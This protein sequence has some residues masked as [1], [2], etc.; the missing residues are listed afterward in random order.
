VLENALFA[1][2][3]VWGGSGLGLAIARSLVEG[4]GGSIEA[5]SRPAEGYDS[6]APSR[7]V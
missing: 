7:L 6:R 3:F 4:H 5:E 1:A 2:V